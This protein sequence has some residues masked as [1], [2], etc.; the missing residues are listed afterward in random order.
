MG[1]RGHRRASLLQPDSHTS[2]R[3]EIQ[4]LTGLPYIV[5][6]CNWYFAVQRRG[7]SERSVVLRRF[8]GWWVW[9]KFFFPVHHIGFSLTRVQSKVCAPQSAKLT[10]SFQ[11]QKDGPFGGR[12]EEIDGRGR[13]SWGVEVIDQLRKHSGW[14]VQAFC[15]ENQLCGQRKCLC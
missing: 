5:S 4:S 10:A 7:L 12:E 8:T 3:G 1:R 14:Q 9:N 2:T 13:D 15:A 6:D 11:V